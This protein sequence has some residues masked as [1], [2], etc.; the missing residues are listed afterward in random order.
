MVEDSPV[1]AE[2]CWHALASHGYDVR[3]DV[4][5]TPEAF[6]QELSR[7]TYDVVLSDF[8]LP[9]WT[10]LE[11]LDLLGTLQ[12]QTPFIL[13]TGDLDEETAGQLID[14]GADDYVHKDRLPR[15][16]LAVRR[17]MRERR[18]FAEIKQAGEERERLLL[19]LKETLDEVKRLNG[20]LPIC[21]TCKRVLNAKGFW[22]RIEIYLERYSDAQVSPSLCPDCAA[23]QQETHLN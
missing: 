10:G 3:L 9:G 6:T 23:R 13:V 14:R 16:P 19:R 17:V 15:L 21:V 18:L 22:S 11:V 12:Q 7:Q 8:H 4:V 20:L 5:A 2:L 1:D